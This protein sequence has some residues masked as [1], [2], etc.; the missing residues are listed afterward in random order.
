[1]TFDEKFC[2]RGI[3]NKGFLLL[4]VVIASMRNRTETYI[5]AVLRAIVTKVG[6]WF[7][8]GYCAVLLL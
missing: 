6:L 5:L 2:K 8:M 7:Y 1:M 4:K 3:S